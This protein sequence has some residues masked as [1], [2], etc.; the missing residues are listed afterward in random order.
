MFA[1]IVWGWIERVS[2]SLPT[3]LS[4]ADLQ[5]LKSLMDLYGKRD[6]DEEVK[7]KNWV[8]KAVLIKKLLGGL[9]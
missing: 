6:D 9:R 7:R 8:V 4:S 5:I 3:S 2:L 1:V